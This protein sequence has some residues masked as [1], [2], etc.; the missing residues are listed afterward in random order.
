MLT[1]QTGCKVELIQQCPKCDTTNKLNV[2]DG[3][4]CNHDC[5]LFDSPWF[6]RSCADRHNVITDGLNTYK[7]IGIKML[8]IPEGYQEL[9]IDDLVN[10]NRHR[11]DVVYKIAPA[12]EL[13]FGTIPLKF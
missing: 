3:L 2:K 4:H 6:S 5:P 8:E 11:A 1:S 7:I 13:L 10:E 12:E 9:T